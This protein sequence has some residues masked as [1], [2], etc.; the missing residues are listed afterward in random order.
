MARRQI[1]GAAFGFRTLADAA[2]PSAHRASHGQPHLETSLRTRHRRAAWAISGRWATG[3][4]HPELLDWLAREFV[5]QG[6]S[7]KS[8]HRLMMTS[9]TY[10]QASAVT[11]QHEQLDP[12]NHLWSRMPHATHGSR[13]IARFVARRSPGNSMRRAS[14]RPSRSKSAAMDW[15]CPANGAAFMSSN[16]ASNRRLCWKASICLR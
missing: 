10:R 11:A 14:A 7:I 1:D 5:R 13:G 4:R 2:R 12:S 3:R 8:M 16:C 15:S 9:N 6:W